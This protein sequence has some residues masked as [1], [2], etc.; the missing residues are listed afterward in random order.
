MLIIYGIS[1]VGS[2]V[3]VNF[4]TL[5]GFIPFFIFGYIVMFFIGFIPMII[6]YYAFFFLAKKFSTNPEL[7]IVFAIITFGMAIPIQIFI[8]RNRESIAPEGPGEIIDN[9]EA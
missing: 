9:P 4:F 5:F 7:H 8:F 2:I 6:M 1:L 3:F